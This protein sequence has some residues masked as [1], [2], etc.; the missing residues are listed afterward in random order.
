MNK[1]FGWESWDDARDHF[2][3]G[4]P[5]FMREKWTSPLLGTTVDLRLLDEPGA[6]EM[7]KGSTAGWRDANVVVL[8]FWA[9]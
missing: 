5:I 9:S 3:E 4:P 8:E 1:V 2:I 7:V 6:L